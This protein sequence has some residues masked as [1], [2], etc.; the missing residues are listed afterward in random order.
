MD[1][2]AQPEQA[3]ILQALLLQPQKEQF[4][5]ILE[6][7]LQEVR[8]EVWVDE[9]PGKGKKATPVRSAFILGPKSHV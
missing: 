5:A 2:K 3:W 6:K 1:N 8:S 4:T 9:R 7:I